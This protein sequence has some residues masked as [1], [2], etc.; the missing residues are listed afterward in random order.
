V[1]DLIP[2]L[3]AIAVGVALVMLYLAAAGAAAA[4]LGALAA[5][6]AVATFVWR[7]CSIVSLGIRTRGGDR[8]VACAPEPAFEIYFSRPL[9]RDF[10]AAFGVAL[11]DVV[12]LAKDRWVQASAKCTKAAVPLAWGVGIGAYLGAAVGV[13]VGGLIAI[14]LGLVVLFVAGFVS[15]G[16]LVL[17]SI[18]RTRRRVR[19]AH[20]DCPECHE[21]SPL[22]VYVCPG[23]G[24]KH[25][26]LLPGRWGVRRRRCECDS[27]SLPVLESGGRHSLTAECPACSHLMPGAGGIVPEVAVPIVGGPKAGKTAFLASLL[28]ELDDRTQAGSSR[29]SVV[30]SSRTAFDQLSGICGLGAC[31]RRRSIVM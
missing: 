8:R 21:R 18:E 27:V 1:D 12:V 15:V 6:E 30:E 16:S 11:Q 26:Q 13:V 22:P 19:G 3:I 5:V 9:V 2:A 25:R 10:R 24:A 28:V 29:L 4:A 14:A 20:F 17:Q 23:C 7:L 31:R